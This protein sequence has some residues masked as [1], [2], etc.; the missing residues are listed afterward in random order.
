MMIHAAEDFDHHVQAPPRDSKA[1]KLQ[2][3]LKP[4]KII[5]IFR[6]ADPETLIHHSPPPAH[7]SYVYV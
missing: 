5:S 6:A 7:S 3:S 4:S 1:F 2:P